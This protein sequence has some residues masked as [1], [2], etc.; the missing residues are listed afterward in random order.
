MQP[1][2][3]G[4]RDRTLY[5]ALA[6]IGGVILLTFLCLWFLLTSEEP[7]QRPTRTQAQTVPR[8]TATDG[9]P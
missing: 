8:P 9:S 7:V 2:R 4:D 6:G 3:R 5:A 1:K